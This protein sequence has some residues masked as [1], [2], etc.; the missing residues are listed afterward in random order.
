[1]K[2]DLEEY[3]LALEKQHQDMQ[4]AVDE[5]NEMIKDG[6][7]SQEQA[8]QILTY[9]STIETNYQRVLY[10]RY[11]YNLPPK[12]IQ[13]IQQKKLQKE[14]EKFRE[15]HADDES[16]IG[17]CQQDLDNINEIVKDDEVSDE[18]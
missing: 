10:C 1:M 8:S 2:K 3:L 16:V 14:M 12:F 15:E 5:A 6:K 4:K 9:M 7:I 18:K 11:L 17:E 13:K